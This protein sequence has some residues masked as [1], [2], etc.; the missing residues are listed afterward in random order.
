MISLQDFIYNRKNALL[1]AKKWAFSRNPK[2]YSFNDIGGDCT[3]FISQ[4]LYAGTKVMNYTPVHGWYYENL[5]NRTP[6]WT[7]VEYL[8][9]FLTNNWGQG[10]FGITSDINSIEVG[11]IIQLGDKNGRFYHSLIITGINAS[12][13]RNFYN[14]FIAT[15]TDDSYMRPL[16]TYFFDNIRFLHILGYRQ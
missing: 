3:N 8:F 14:I 2:Y 11:D 6:S 13:N 9:A 15:H 1:Y 7:G 12:T 4:C 10:P 16:S 5:N